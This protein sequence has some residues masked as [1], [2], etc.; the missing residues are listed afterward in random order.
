MKKFLTPEDMSLENFP[1]RGD[2]AAWVNISQS[3]RIFPTY[4]C[5]N[6]DSIAA[7]APTPYCPNCGSLMVNNA[8]V[9]AEHL[10]SVDAWKK[11]E[12]NKDGIQNVQGN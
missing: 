4:K 10:A 11:E 6:C 1:A 5:S 8:A 2:I 9:Q 3:E 7:L 12:V